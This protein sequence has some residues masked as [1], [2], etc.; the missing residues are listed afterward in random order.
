MP[1]GSGTPPATTGPPDDRFQA[2][3]EALEAA[4][5]L[6][7]GPDPDVERALAELRRQARRW[8]RERSAVHWA[9]VQLALA[10]ALLKRLIG[11]EGANARAALTKAQA[12]LAVLGRLPRD[13]NLA[14]AYAVTGQAYARRTAGRAEDNLEEALGYLGTSMLLSLELEDACGVARAV[15][16]AADVLRQ[17]R[18]EGRLEGIRRAIELLLAAQHMLQANDL[19]VPPELLHNLGVAQLE[20]PRPT[21]E[22]RRLAIAAFEAA[23]ERT[24]YGSV[25]W[26]VTQLDLAQARFLAER[27]TAGLA[28]IRSD[29]ET[30]AAVFQREWAPHHFARAVHALG[31][32]R[33]QLGDFSGARADYRLALRTAKKAGTA[34]VVAARMRASLAALMLADPGAG[35]AAPSR[36][37]RQYEL[38]LATFERAGRLDDQLLVLRALADDAFDRESWEV[39][40]ARLGRAIALGDRLLERAWTP[41]GRRAEIGATSILHAKAAY[42]A[43]QLGRPDRALER[44]ERGRARMLT[45]ALRIRGADVQRLPTRDQ[46]R[47]RSALAAVDRLEEQ[48]PDIVRSGREPHAQLRGLRDAE[49]RFEAVI[50]DLRARHRWFMPDGLRVPDVLREV[51][52][53]GALVAPVVTSHGAECFVIPA[54]R[55]R[56]EPR[57]VVRLPDLTVELLRGMLLG[58]THDVGWFEAYRDLL[59]NDS[60][61]MWDRW[62]SCVDATCRRLWELL[63]GPV[64]GRLRE[65]GLA[66]GAEVVVLPQ[67]GLGVVPLHAAAREDGDA[68]VRWFLDDWCVRYAPSAYAIAAAARARPYGRRN[69]VAVEDPSAQLPAAPAEVDAIARRFRSGAAHVLGAADAEEPRVVAALRRRRYVHFACHAVYGWEDP[70]ASAL[71]MADGGELDLEEVIARVR[72]DRARLVALSACETG[73][74]EHDLEPDE[75][76]GLAAGFMAAGAKAVLSS[77]WAVGDLPAC[78]L[79]D[80]FYALHL[81]ERVPPAAA[82][83]A[84]QRW[85]RDATPAEIDADPPWRDLAELPIQLESDWRSM[86]EVGRADP[87]FRPFDHPI[88]WAAFTVTGA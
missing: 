9:I 29:L 12:G 30:A 40:E 4:Q 34:P 1:T 69:L 15:I 55:P 10:Q 39:A 16:A 42:C 11:D 84:A 71:E 22:Q 66:P 77:L 87:S 3:V 54:G 57:D 59:A 41:S 62:L 35:A 85:L 28:G 78:V 7:F 14:H 63:M 6:L 51:P 20:L 83:R 58:T 19:Q 73:V 47:F 60:D 25:D 82:L 36:A 56:V 48:A 45:A 75:Y 65:L 72:L 76:V 53:G 43:L 46:R 33:A 81:G 68:G 17:Q 49:G 32:V 88:D 26:A 5:A 52:P 86:G 67:G 23:L 37:R 24:R 50:A 61:A 79:M 80:R 70:M 38:A 64:D 27:G 2:D 21:P 74:S 8:P 44:L 13:A 31:Q 18:G